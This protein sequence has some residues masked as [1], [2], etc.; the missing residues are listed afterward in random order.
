VA[1]VKMT[2]KPDD[3]FTLVTLGHAKDLRVGQFV[4]A[5]GSPFQFEDTVTFGI[6]SSL[7]REL[8]EPGS[9]MPEPGAHPL[10]MHADYSGLIQTDASINPGNSGGPLVNM[11]GEVV[12]INFAIYSPGAVGSSVGIG[13]AIP[14]DT[15]E[16]V[17]E[18]LILKGHV[19]RGVIGLQIGDAA[20]KAEEDKVS[21]EQVKQ[22]FGTDTGAF[23]DRVVPGAAAD[24]AG[25]QK[26]D[27][28]VGVGDQPVKSSR[29][30]TDIIRATKPGTE[31]QLKIL[32]DRQERTVPV[33]VAELTPDLT[34]D[35]PAPDR[36]DQLAQLGRDPLGLTVAAATPAELDKAAVAEGVKVTHVD[37]DGVAKDKDI[38]A[39]TLLLAGT[40]ND[41]KGRV[42]FTDPAAYTAFINKAAK[43]KAY[44]MLWL[45]MPAK[46]GK[47]TTETVTVNFGAPA[48]EPGQ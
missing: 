1:V 35:Q 30:L 15:A 12:G 37:D 3:K 28:V 29:E 10:V 26:D 19:T 11:N 36:P 39:G 7:N 38:T 31:V 44:V 20:R 8:S 5:V 41:D 24:K 16:K 22:L 9:E 27:V 14:V 23:V 6:V 2:R 4:M 25:L 13:F 18:D 21:L 43:D 40:R 48:A 47:Y 33:T 32:R 34:G 45:A 42:K 17:V 46:G